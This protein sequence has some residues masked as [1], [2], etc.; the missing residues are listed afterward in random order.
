MP[1]E[2]VTERLLLTPLRADDAPEM[3]VVLADPRMYEFT[4]GEPPTLEALRDRYERLADGR[5]PDGSEWW[6]NWIIRLDGTAVG[7]VQATVAVDGTTADVAWEVG[8]EWQGRG[9][10]GE[11]AGAMVRWLLDQDVAE[12]RALVHPD[13]AAS[14]GVAARIG[15]T[16]TAELEDGEV[17]WRRRTS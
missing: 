1:T 12:V 14:A 7:V 3:V 2:L 10:A 17:V 5:S 8:V 4:G 6:W 9:V 13:H 15:L 16:R 11:A